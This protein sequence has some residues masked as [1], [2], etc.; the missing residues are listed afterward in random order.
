LCVHSS[1]VYGEGATKTRIDS[2]S[3]FLKASKKLIIIQNRSP[4]TACGEGV[5][6]G[7]FFDLEVNFDCAIYFLEQ[8]KK[9][10]KTDSAENQ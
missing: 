10:N 9:E 3:L 1:P 2:Y 6:G 5:G 4:L 8:T 7:V